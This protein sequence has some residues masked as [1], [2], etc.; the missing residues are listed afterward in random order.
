MAL[1]LIQIPQVLSKLYS[2]GGHTWNVYLYKEYEFLFCRGDG[3]FTQETNDFFTTILRRH[4][5]TDWLEQKIFRGV[6]FQFGFF[7]EKREIVV[8][9]PRLNRELFFL[10]EME[11]RN[12]EAALNPQQKQDFDRLK[13]HTEKIIALP[14][15]KMPTVWEQVTLRWQL[16]DFLRD[17]NLQNISLQ[18]G[19]QEKKLVTAMNL[20]HP[21]VIERISDQMLNWTTEYAL[22]RVYLLKFIALLPSL[23]FDKNGK[24]HKRLLLEML[25]RTVADSAYARAKNFTGQNQALPL[26]MERVMWASHWTSHLIPGRVLVKAIRFGAMTL[27]KRF[28]AG[29]SMDIAEA[30]LE[31]LL[32]S[33][34]DASLCQL[35][36]WVVSKEDAD[37]YQKSVL[38]LI[39]DFQHHFRKGEKNTAGLF[40]AHVSIKVSALAHDF[41][42]TAFDYTFEQVAPRLKAILETAAQESVFVQI[43]AEHYSHRDTVFE[44]VQ[45]VLLDSKTLQNF[46]ATG[47]VLQ[48]YL[49]DASEHLTTIEN[50][51]KARG[52]PMPVRIV[53]GAYWDAETIEADAQGWDAPQ[54]LNKEETDLH[55]RQLI[56]K[57][58]ESPH[59]QLVIGSHNL[60]DHTFAET[61]HQTKF[62]KSPPIEHQCLHMT[63]EALSFGMSRMGW[64]V[65]NYVTMG[66]L[67]EG[68]AYL[69][70][71]IME[72]SSSVGILSQSRS[73][74]L[75]EKVAPSYM[76][77]QRKKLM[78]EIKRDISISKPTQNFLNVIPQRIFLSEERALLQGTF[79]LFKQSELGKSYGHDGYSGE[80]LTVTNPS[81]P[82]QIVGLVQQATGEDAKRAI[83]S[84]Y[85]TYT[86]G[87]W[88]ETDPIERISILLKAADRM[89]LQRAELASLIV[90]EG[91]KTFNES[92]NDVNEAIDFLNFYAREEARRTCQK[93]HLVSRGPFVVISPWN[94]PLA[95]PCGMVAAPLVAGNTVVLKPAKHTPLITERFV[96]LMYHAGVP[97]DALI[98]LPGPGAILGDVLVN[99]PK[100]AGVVFT[101]SKGVGMEITHNA[102][103]R[104]FSNPLYRFDIPTR[105]IT[106]MGGKNGI[107]VMASA[108]L[109]EAVKGILYSAFGNSGQKCSACSRIIVDNR[110]KEKLST[111]LTEAL[112]DLNVGPAEDFATTM[113]PLI[114]KKEKETLQNYA[115]EATQEAELFGGQVL[116]DRSRENLPGYCMGPVLIELMMERSFH[117]E[118][119]AQKE[120]FGPILHVIGF[121]T[122]EEA[123]AIFN[124]TEYGLTG[125][126]FS[127][128]QDDIDYL[129]KRLEAGNLYV[130]RHCT[131]ARVAIEP[132]GGLKLSGTGPKAG[133]RYYLDAFHVD[134]RS[135]ELAMQQGLQIDKESLDQYRDLIL[136]NISRFQKRRNFNRNIPGQISYNDMSIIKE[137]GVYIA[138]EKD[139]TIQTFI[140][141]LAALGL[142]SHITI[143]CENEPAHNTWTNLVTLLR[144]AGIAPESLHL[145]RGI[146]KTQLD[147]LQDEDL[148][149]FIIEGGKAKIEE[150]LELI[151]NNG[152]SE[153]HMRSIL[154]KL[155]APSLKDF[156][157]Y[158]E[159]FISIRSFAVNVMHHG[160]PMEVL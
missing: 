8:T 76:I 149:F 82:N 122:K 7:P 148:H 52:M 27:A 146:P 64:A 71:R 147:L 158:L 95:I 109:D 24:E 20:Y 115:I 139:P 67:L 144:E 112:R 22:I 120:L 49:R 116:L 87:R 65:R 62:P 118:S 91:G 119:C 46:N 92:M 155:D 136:E 129:L 83:D 86:S 106:E 19:E 153:H 96:H 25:R 114:G 60:G 79:D 104:I 59:L 21:T 3:D 58:L 102:G 4:F 84:L 45:K 157:K 99:S 14:I 42:P 137:A 68:M 74:Q 151:Y 94:F 133:S 70:R 47:P 40:R 105:I 15:D 32:E 108:D 43:D 69:V 128:S 124:S 150:T 33:N 16:P 23:S 141:F 18:A 123:V 53:K 1:K 135:T 41:N 93:D 142:G 61:L 110:I 117:K 29:A 26:W 48:A 121:D 55:F 100:T 51:A 160:A 103:K 30:H 50:L 54:F 12:K 5:N 34:R 10:S 107:L 126:L 39:F 11:V 73:H 9:T 159:Q 88:S 35:G 75:Q 78:G 101:G 154:T 132:F 57:I 80:T 111:R 131:G 152:F 56:H 6:P 85:Q 134:I 138:S 63:Y 156:D 77:H 31:K 89:L 145:K 140:Y 38:Q 72:N 28:I 98:H 90:L 66:N 17:R 125:G 81:E 97:H 13:N 130:N 36:E 37:K 44:I 113:N 143:L 127:Q 2:L